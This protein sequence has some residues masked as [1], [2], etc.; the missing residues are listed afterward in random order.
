MCYADYVVAVALAAYMA[1]MAIGAT[2]T[3]RLV[4]PYG[5]LLFG[6]YVST[7]MIVG[8]AFLMAVTNSA[9]GLIA[10]NLVLG[11]GVGVGFVGG[12]ATAR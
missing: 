7:A 8:P 2:V 4:S 11:V 6:R 12:F 1:G 5:R 10:C 9:H 3:G